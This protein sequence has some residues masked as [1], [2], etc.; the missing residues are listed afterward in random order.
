MDE[1]AASEFTQALAIILGA[2]IDASKKVTALESALKEHDPVFYNQYR[3]QLEKD[4][5][6]DAQDTLGAQAALALER[7][8][9]LLEK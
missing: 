9:G 2:Y 7:L 1:Q 3:N 4:K 6:Q 8:Q 5:Q